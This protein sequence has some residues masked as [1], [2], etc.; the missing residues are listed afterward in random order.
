[1][2]INPHYMR[3]FCQA[4][5][6]Y[7]KG[8][9]KGYMISLVGNYCE[10]YCKCKCQDGFRRIIRR[11]GLSSFYKKYGF[12]F[13]RIWMARKYAYRQHDKDYKEMIK[14]IRQRSK[15]SK[16]Q[17]EDFVFYQPKYKDRN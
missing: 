15:E 12:G 16:H 8:V 4:D 1:M 14:D 13:W 9:E 5:E 7:K 2:G 6:E 3:G 10:V 17:Y 11:R